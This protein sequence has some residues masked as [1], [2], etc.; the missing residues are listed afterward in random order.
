MTNILSIFL[1]SRGIFTGI[2]HLVPL[3]T[4]FH[5]PWNG[6][7]ITSHL[8][9][10]CCDDNRLVEAV[11]NNYYSQ[12]P[13]TCQFPATYWG[14]RCSFDLRFLFIYKCEHVFDCLMQ[15]LTR[16][17]C[18]ATR[19]RIISW[20]SQEKRCYS[21]SATLKILSIV[22]QKRSWGPK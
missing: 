17:F 13:T 9:G 22:T 3:S 4:V 11:A 18:C 16:Q 12:L 7:R 15:L 5:L 6:T 10:C 14:T 19:D 8:F 21:N 2:T 1:H 20:Y